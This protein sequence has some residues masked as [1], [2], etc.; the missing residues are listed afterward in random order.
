MEQSNIIYRK[1]LPK[2]IYKRWRKQTLNTY[3][4]FDVEYEQSVI[5]DEN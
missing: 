2:D 1:R 5:R 3:K 4:K